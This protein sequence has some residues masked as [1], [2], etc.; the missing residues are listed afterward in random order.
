[1][2]IIPVSSVKNVFSFVAVTTTMMMMM[3]T[4]GVN[5]Q[6]DLISCSNNQCRGKTVNC[7]GDNHCTI[8]CTSPDACSDSTFN[9][10]YD[11]VCQFEVSGTHAMRNSIINNGIDGSIHITVQ[12]NAGSASLKNTQINCGNGSCYVE[13]NGGTNTFEGATIDASDAYYLTL[14]SQ[15][16]YAYASSTIKC[17]EISTLYRNRCE[18]VIESGSNALQNA[19]IQNQDS[20][21]GL[22]FTCDTNSGAS[23]CDGFIMECNETYDQTCTGKLV[24]GTTTNYL[25]CND[26]T[27]FCT[28]HGYPSHP[29]IKHGSFTRNDIS[30]FE[31]FTDGPFSAD[32]TVSVFAHMETVHDPDPASLAITSV[33]TT[34]FTSYVMEESS[35]GD[36]DLTHTASEDCGYIA[37]GSLGSIYNKKWKTIGEVGTVN[38]K[39]NFDG[40]Y[41]TQEFVNTYRNP[42]MYMMPNTKNNVDLYHIRLKDVTTTSFKYQIEEWEYLDGITETE[43]FLV[44]VVV[45]Q[46][47]HWLPNDGGLLQA[48]TTYPVKHSEVRVT[49]NRSYDSMNTPVVLSQSQTRNGADAIVTRQKDN[50]GT[51]ITLY[52]QEESVSNGMHNIGETVG[53]I[54]FQT[55]PFP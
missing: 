14:T 48:K 39:Q 27:E 53:V 13:N 28:D 5:G 50:D 43:D 51:G 35:D 16:D 33:D 55:G 18:I 22:E 4:T 31:S 21:A 45:E 26:E 2:T 20:F 52:V 9:C 38:V 32:S 46:G 24:V 10:P 15:Q 54:A 44:Y 30:E 6:C 23:N 12:D 49:F 11:E 8:L 25:T 29:E 40:Q 19:I 42:V 3:M 36:S 34:G 41:R 37:F 17:P 1:M 47:V 7:P